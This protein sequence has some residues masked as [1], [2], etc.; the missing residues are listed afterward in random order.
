MHF[1]W[2]NTGVRVYQL[3]PEKLRLWAAAAVTVAVM[4]VASFA[5]EES[6]DN[7]RGNR[8]ISL[9]GLAV[10]IAVLWATSRDRSKIRWHT[11]IGGM[12]TQ[13]IIAL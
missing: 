11:V 10:M 8:A 13:F 6:A 9:L 1:I 5:S 7:T 12:L 4:L 3:V 2:N